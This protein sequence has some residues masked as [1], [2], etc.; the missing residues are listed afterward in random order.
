MR[1]SLAQMGLWRKAVRVQFGAAYEDVMVQT[2]GDRTTA[3]EYGHEAMQRKLLEYRVEGERFAALSEALRFTPT[4]ELAAFVADGEK[5]DLLERLARERPDPI[6]PRRDL[7]AGETAADF[8]A[9]H[10]AWLEE[11]A[12]SQLR[13]EEEVE[14]RLRQ[15]IAELCA[16]P[17]EELIAPARAR[18]IDIECWNAFH[19]ASDDWVLFEATR[20]AEDPAQLY[21]TG[22]EEVRRLHPEV[23]AQL[24]AAYR[25]LET[26]A[27]GV[28]QAEADLPKACCATGDF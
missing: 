23:R 19:Q 18:R 5:P 15:R 2:I 26:P 12:Q 1:M 6:E 27:V 17:K 21:F 8:A 25:E 13:R 7:A 14:R 11:C 10:Q 9:R 20:R 28:D 16:R 24:A 3:L 22:V 4:E